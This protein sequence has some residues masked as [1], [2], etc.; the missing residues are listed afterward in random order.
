MSLTLFLKKISNLGGKYDRLISATFRGYT[1][2]A[3][4]PQCEYEAIINEEFTWPHYG[5]DI[6]EE[7]LEIKVYNHSKI[8]SNR[9]LGHM[10]I[11]LQQVTKTGRLVLREA[12]V[13]KNNSLTDILV[14]LEIR[15]QPVEGAVGTWAEN[16]FVVDMNDSALIIQNRNV[17]DPSTYDLDKAEQLDKETRS[18]G[19][20]LVN[21]NDNE[22]E[23]DVDISEIDIS[24]VSFTPQ[25]SRSR[26]FTKADL[27]T[28]R[29]QNFQIAV[30]IFEAR[31]LIGVNIDPVVHVKVG[32]ERK[33]TSTQKSTNCP[34]YNEYFIFEFQEPAAVLFDKIIEIIVVHAKKIP[35]TGVQLGLFRI[36][37]GTVYQQPDHGFYQ[38]WAILTDPKDTKSGIKGFV[39]CTITVLGKGDMQG[40]NP[41]VITTQDEDVE[42]N[43]LLPKQVPLER[44]WAKFYIKLY[45]AE[46]LPSMNSGFMGSLSKIL[47]E[48]KV[49]IDPY[50]QV[51]FAGQQGET[52]VESNTTNPVWNEQITFVEMF[53]P[54]ARRIK[55]QVIDDAN[56][57]DVAIATHFLNLHEISDPRINAGFY[58]TFG[59]A[60][61]YLY[62]SPQ[63]SVLRDAYRDLNE[64]LGEGIFYRGRILIAVSVDV[65]SSI[66]AIQSDKGKKSKGTFKLRKKSK[67]S[68]SKSKAKEESHSQN[69]DEDAANALEQPSAM[70]V[71]VDTIHPVPESVTGEKEEFLLFAG[72]FEATM[73]DPSVRSRLLTFEVS[74]GNC[75]KLVEVVTK[76]KKEEKVEGS[77]EKRSLLDSRDSEDELENTE[78]SLSPKDNS[79]TPPRKA[80]NTEYDRS[81]CCV[82][83]LYEKPCVYIW[84]SWEDY[85]WRLYNS[86]VLAKIAERLEDG[87]DELLHMVK[88]PKSEPENYLCQVLNEFVAGCRQYHIYAEKKTVN[89]PNALDRCRIK[90]LKCNIIN[91]AKQALRIMKRKEKNIKEKL[92]ELQTL[93]EKF[94]RRVEEPQTPIPDIFIWMLSNGK[95]VAV[96][97]IPAR[98][99]LYSVV[100]E[101]KGKDCGKIQSII[102]KAQG[103]PIGEIFAKLEVYMW[104]GVTKSTKN[105]INSLPQEYIPVY[106]E[107]KMDTTRILPPIKLNSDYNSYFQ[108]RAHM[109]QARGLLAADD[110]GLSDPFARVVFSTQCQSTRYLEETLSPMWSEM[111][112]FD[113]ILIEGSKEE[114]KND[115]PII[116]INIFDFDNFGS[117]EFLGRAFA[118]PKIKLQD[119]QYEKPSLEFHDIYKGQ[120]RGGELLAAFELIELDYSGYGEPS[121]PED[122][123]SRHPEFLDVQ[124]KHFIIPATIRP[125]LKKFRIEVLFWGLRDL[126]RINLFEVEQPQVTMECGGQKVESEIIASYKENPN[127][128]ELAKYFEVELPE[129]MYLH[130]PLSIV[131]VEQRAFGRTVLVGSYTVTN[132]QQFSLKE[133]EENP[134]QDTAAKTKRKKCD[135]QQLNG[136]AASQISVNIETEEL[137]NEKKKG[138]MKVL[139]IPMK[140]LA[141][142]P[143]SE[144][145]LEEF[146]EK[147]DLEELDW[148]SKY[149]ASVEEMKVKKNEEEE[150]EEVAELVDPS[151]PSASDD[152][153]K[154]LNGS[155]E[156]AV[157][158]G[159]K[160]IATFQIYNTE[161]EKQFNFQD[162]LFIFPL[163]R[164][165][166]NEDEFEENADDR[167]MGKCKGSLL[168]YPSDEVESD[169]KI[170]QGKPTNRPVK[171][172]VRV[173]VVK[174]TNLAPTDLNGK[175]DPY[176]VVKISEQ[177][178]DSKERYIPKQLN[179]V[180]GE[181]F[182]MTVA[183]PMETELTVSIF[184]HDMVGKDDL[185]G[186]TKLD[187]ENRY[188]S[189]HRA[190]CG[191]PTQYDVEGY[192][193]WRDCLKPTQILKKL[194]KD[195]QLPEP[196]YRLEEVKVSNKIFKIPND[197]LPIENKKGEQPV[198]SDEQKALY[199]LNQWEDMPEHS[200]KMVPEHIEIR[201]LQKSDNPGMSQGQVHMWVDMFPVDLPAPPP[202]NI[203]PRQPISYELRV[204]IWN[205][206]D[207][208]LDDVN[209]LTGVRSSDIYIK[210]W[211]KGLENDKQETDVHFNSLTGEGNFNWRFVFRFDYLPTE[212]EIV[213]K[214]K[215]SIFSLEES[216]FRQPA[217]LV[218]QIWDYDLISAN[219]F[220]GS[221][222]LKLND[223][224]RGAKTADQCTIKMAK[225]KAGPRASIIRGKR[226]KGWWPMIKVKEAEDEEEEE[227]NES[228]KK[229][230]KKK[231]KKVKIEDVEFTDCSGN[232]YILRGK[233]EAEM[234]LLTLEEAE[235]SPVGLGRKEPEPLDK[236]NRPNTSFN[237]FINPLK[238]F[239]YFIWK[240]YKWYIVGLL[241]I[242]ILALFIFLILYTMPQFISEK[243]ING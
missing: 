106:E 125:R 108:L 86:N 71:S 25:K 116:I 138:P 69:E 193:A 201:Q 87:L 51:T 134:N 13:D 111:L 166:A 160:N 2:S 66:S 173:Y 63:N 140:K 94:K 187:L 204:I 72:F 74:I 83:Y 76:K 143:K 8:F 152:V 101:E 164:G 225:E 136:K 59:P 226:M 236:P 48:H 170:L 46:D 208:P 115:P 195:L 119:E 96:A 24:S 30:T 14:D 216:E 217:V 192:N 139:K 100:E 209:P 33:H 153:E 183:F 109:Y 206:D 6:M 127:F 49:F 103:A 229:K 215:E 176:I 145:G 211:L 124:E 82:P 196:E 60:W 43:L 26:F 169:F 35:F 181:V 175:S 146:E 131:V 224:I 242:V 64:G 102:M 202:V 3:R 194:C 5:G 158:R 231:K 17:E 12:L 117:P 188:Y 200:I 185:I 50:I 222:E 142:K 184:D 10:R 38:K 190:Q 233:V 144:S 205:T 174:A 44:P 141:L 219:D 70:E 36:D 55:I 80:E 163:Y 239:V 118:V 15:Y 223:M 154:E 61:V 65:F 68:K 77:E 39:K 168:I 19:R 9:L 98:Q 92:N 107:V 52:S 47:G 84:S 114:L 241:V 113:Q 218:L 29:I 105:I 37:A 78:V 159:K 186:E 227:D 156:Q 171:V 45:K 133:L 20:K 234:H 182:E 155:K 189:R 240:N 180:F 110:T 81:Y 126:K 97:R 120:T 16:D 199:V 157:T 214:K 21:D 28:P 112:L 27:H 178:Q 22:D 53:P 121:L 90:T 42:R 54:L 212:K 122:V 235:K 32:D 95:R 232:T 207:V 130:P 58:P 123:E 148:W 23:D 149:Y 221:V 147:I 34:F 79:I 220:L 11:S 73:I 135:L 228:K 1:Y 161:L 230:K 31:K 198:L 197:L 56:I 89:R 91:H 172:L 203:K 41:G 104:L 93:L 88:R 4:R 167:I 128:T 40:G 151:N 162:W 57:N 137:T 210:G 243:I 99:I 179:P 238:S 67:K 75:G 129:Q 132:L 62:G 85:S 191:L 7:M 177:V 18:L 150:E 165:K 237:W 213:Y